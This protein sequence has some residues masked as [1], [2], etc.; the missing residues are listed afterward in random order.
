MKKICDGKK[1]VVL[2]CARSGEATARWALDQ[3]A[4]VVLSDIK[5][6]T[7]W[8]DELVTWAKDKADV[9]LDAGGH[10]LEQWQDADMVV[11]SPGIPLDIEPV[12]FMREKGVRV[13]GE[14]FLAASLWKGRMAGI[15]GTNG[16]T[17]T[18]KLLGEICRAAGLDTV[19]AGN[20]GEPFINSVMA[21]EVHGNDG[22]R[23][24][25]LELSSFQLENF[26]QRPLFE[27]WRIPHF[28]VMAWLNF[29][30]DHLD[31][32]VDLR[33]YGDAK[34]RFMEFQTDSDWVILNRDCRQM[35]LWEEKARAKK[36]Y[37]GVMRDDAP[38]GAWFLKGGG[39]MIL[40]MSGDREE[41]YDLS[42]WR[43]KG[44]HNLE[45]LAAAM[46][47]AR[48][49]EIE[50]QAIE[51]A[52]AGFSPPSHRLEFVTEKQGI[53]FYDDSKATN[54]GAVLTAIKAMDRPVVLIAGGRGK[55]EDYSALANSEV[56]E[57]L[58]A[59]VLIGEEADR[60]EKVFASCVPTVRLQ[61]DGDVAGCQIMKKAVEKAMERAFAGDVVLLSPA[62][63]SFD[64]FRNYEERGRAFKEAAL[65]L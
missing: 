58:K 46:L 65:G 37:F 40:R 29:A 43:L 21:D 36:L 25:V 10:N 55:G 3:G 30:P 35:D 2:G 34:A 4:K 32:Y 26:E 45:N 22:Q 5:P 57:R 33:H 49:L 19:V 62:C 28:D 20:I 7:A 52:I 63:A 54:V 27:G 15:T 12:R 51:R 11:V 53:I 13:T 24:A 17:T 39:E 41:R 8:P 38:S 31:R 18:T 1:I 60:L 64:L 42:G 16:K 14:L 9:T 61:T 48:C 23:V 44:V 50:K 6:L 59:V 56:C 47:S